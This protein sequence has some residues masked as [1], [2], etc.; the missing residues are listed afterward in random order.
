MR[1]SE[2]TA[3]RMAPSV[4]VYTYDR[5]AQ[6]V[7][8]VHLGIGAFHRAHQAWYTDAAMNLGCRNWMITGVSFRSR[9]TAAQMNAQNGLYTVTERSASSVKVRLV[10]AVRHVLP[11][12]QA[13]SHS[14]AIIACR[15]TRIVS[16]TITEK[17][18]CRNADG[19]LNLARAEEATSIYPTLV[20]GLRR[21]RADNLGGLT[22]LSCD[23]LAGNGAQ[24][25]SLIQQFCERHEPALANWIAAECSFPSTMVDRI[26]PAT[27]PEDV[28]QVS[29]HTGV[30]DMAAVMTEPF[31]QWVIEDRFSSGRP[32]WEKVGVQMVSDAAPYEK[33]K[34]RMLNA[35]HS[36]LAYLGLRRGHRYVHEAVV[37]PS[38]NSVVSAIML[39]E[40]APSIEVAPSQDL[41]AY[42]DQ[43]L[44]RFRNPELRHELRQIA[45]DGSQKIPQR[46]LE[47]LAFHRSRDESCPGLLEAIGAWLSHLGSDPLLVSDPLKERAR[48]IWEAEGREGIVEAMFGNRGLFAQIWTANEHDLRAITMNTIRY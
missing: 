21:R 43:L 19:T 20:E 6:A 26:V 22:V 13:Q 2:K 46:W 36:A 25:A 30:Q 29:R 11:S 7:G 27:T 5:A 9:E 34:L 28:T 31:S 44:E 23:N 24:L 4:D 18:Y 10:G 35:S 47:T 14:P 15:T 32:A 17:G 48:A 42:H 39:R 12:S 8:I 37:D 3:S 16:L 38:I 41:H 33:A 45:M 40:A 1:L